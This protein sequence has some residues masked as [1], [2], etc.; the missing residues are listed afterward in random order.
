MAKPKAFRRMTLSFAPRTDTQEGHIKR[1]YFTYGVV[2]NHTEE[3]CIIKP[4]DIVAYHTYLTLTQYNLDT[5]LISL[6]DKHMHSS[7]LQLPQ[8]DKAAGERER[9]W[10]SD[11]IALLPGTSGKRSAK[12]IKADF[13][14]T[15]CKLYVGSNN[16]AADSHRA[17]D[18]NGK[19]QGSSAFTLLSNLIINV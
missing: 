6:D 4:N 5:A 7:K 9:G 15:P 13:T 14:P 3:T 16:V 19:Q 12:P 2:I 10:N 17:T 18:E 1:V 8:G 11:L